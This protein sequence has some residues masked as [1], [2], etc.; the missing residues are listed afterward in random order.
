MS[1]TIQR[2]LCIGLGGTGRDV[3]MQIRRLIID[4]YGRLDALPV[5]GFVHIDADKGA[6]DI[7]GLSTGNSYRGENIL[8]TPAERVI[9][10]MTSQEIDQLLGGLEQQG[11]FD[12]KSPY[13]HIKS[14]LP[15]Q[16][17]RN[18]KAIEDGAG[19]IRPV[20]RLSFFH[21]YR[22]IKAAIETAEN[23]TRG[24]EQAMLGHGFS[25]EPGL[26]IFVVGS[27]CGGTGS[28][29]FLDVA[30]AL[31]KAYGD[32]ENKLVGY[33]IISP[34]LYGDTP[35]MNANVYAALKELNHY[36]AS[37]T[38]FEAC[39]DPQQLVNIN[40]DRPPFDFTYILSN[41]T[42]TDYRILDK[43]KLCNVV[44][45]KIFLDFGD[46]LTS[47]IK[48]QKDN[49]RDKLTRLDSHPRR[50]IQRYLTFGLA[51]IY[52]PQ[53]RIGKMALTKVSQRLVKFWLKGI[54]Q[55]P[56]PGL[57]LNRFLSKWGDSDLE[58]A[59]P[60]RLQGMVLDNG[61]TFV[62][63]LKAWGTKIEQEIGLVQKPDDR[64]QL[65]LQLRS[66][67]RAQ[68]RKVQ[69]GE[70]DDIR[71]A[72]LTRIQKTQPQL[73]NSIVNEIGQ[74]FGELLTPSHPEFSLNSARGWLE[75]ILTQ[76]NDYQRGLEDYIQTKD[77]L[78]TPE[79]LDTQWRSAERRLQDLE[80]K[81]GFLGVLDNN[82]Q[83]NK[84][85]QVEAT[86]IVT[87]TKKLIQENFDY[88]LHKSALVI[89]TEV[90]SFIRALIQQAGT[91][92]QLL[93]SVERNFE[94]C[95]EDLERLNTDG[96][97]GE[98][99]FSPEDAN[100]CYLD[101]LP[102]QN[103]KAI[104]IDISGQILT[105]KFIFVEKS[106]LYFLVQVT[107]EEK[108]ATSSIRYQVRSPDVDD[109]SLGTNITATIDKIF[110]TQAIGSLQ[111]VMA[112][113][114]QKYPLASGNA[115][116]R[117]RQ[118]IS[119]AQPLLPLLV[120]DGHFYEDGGN[121]SEIIAFTRTDDRSSQQLQELLTRNVG[122]A[123]STI[124][125]IQNN[126]EIVIVNEYAAFPLRLIQGIDRMREHY[127][128]EYSQ[129]RSRIHND[130]RQVFSE[131]IPPDARRMEEMQDAFYACLAF[132][133]LTAQDNCYLYE[134]ED[135]FGISKNS[136]QLSLVWSEALEQISKAVGIANSLN[137][138]RKDI[139]TEIQTDP[140]QW[141]DLYLP[142]LKTFIQYVVGLPREHPNYP[143]IGIVWGEDMTIDRA[144]TEGILKRLWGYL[145][146]LAKT[147]LVN[148]SKTLQA[149]RPTTQDRESSLGEID[150]DIIDPRV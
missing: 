47:V 126:S 21:N 146:K 73:T 17:I 27:L 149:Q 48:S 61:K 10:T 107:D 50:N 140:S 139:I 144:A 123:E 68:F 111:P 114:L 67:T 138:R 127:D 30:Y 65:L 136:I 22:K 3:L 45:H 15:P 128:R 116:R 46:E 63:A 133:I 29:M 57:L 89:A 62:Q 148:S 115:E 2:T 74:F 43:N 24:H 103:E 38:R 101:F 122:I 119:E 42:A 104:L 25:V 56:D 106:L 72:W 69:P 11:E 55:S 33:W 87:N 64:S 41:R 80:E 39:Y 40:E 84:D 131:I 91:L 6:S 105:D 150:A 52:S 124:K 36:A 9:A 66:E 32:I 90:S 130:Y 71:G 16:L 31:R 125:S 44:A 135:E 86:Q 98:A 97:T 100:T 88:Q 18:V 141:Q 34:E 142:R 77:G 12:R 75:A 35:S 112:R 93:T 37:N 99:L 19:G 110:G 113:F 121:K 26:N 70:S 95:A 49:F 132:G 145:D 118:I 51:K 120:R 23:R 108:V 13:D 92:S 134:I 129:N 83:K 79:D 143:E 58:R 54:G 20:G 1:Q 53:D 28:G 76:I 60:Y 78:A 117:M 4:R 81:K 14:W 82:K 8:F 147:N 102:E 137:A 5:V 96:I 109:R 85:F 94:K 59:F 7:S